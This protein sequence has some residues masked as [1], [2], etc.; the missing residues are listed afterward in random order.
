MFR[1]M[2][3]LIGFY[4]IIVIV[5]YSCIPTSTKAISDKGEVLTLQPSLF[6]LLRPRKDSTI[7]LP[8]LSSPLGT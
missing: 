3:V 4:L 7:L 5:V 6:L 2:Y 8:Y 1:S